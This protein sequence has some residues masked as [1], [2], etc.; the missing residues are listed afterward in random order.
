MNNGL[1]KGGACMEN[2]SYRGEDTY[3]YADKIIVISEDF[4]KNLLTKG[5][6]EEK[7]VVVYNWVDQ[8]AV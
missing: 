1:S 2:W 3:K 4:K 7:I 6:P 5:V 8:N